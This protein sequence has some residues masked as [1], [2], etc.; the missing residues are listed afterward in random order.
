MLRSSL[1]TILVCVLPITGVAEIDG[2]AGCGRV[3]PNYNFVYNGPDPLK[4]QSPIVVRGTM[5]ERLTNFGIPLTQD[6]LILALRNP[7]PEVRYVAALRLADDDANGA[8]PDIVEA[9]GAERDPRARAYMA[10]ALTELGDPK[11]VQELH[12]AC[13]DATFPTDVKLDVAKFLLE[14]H[15][16]S[17]PKAVVAGF[18]AGAF[19]RDYAEDTMEFFYR[20]SPGQY[21]EVR[22]LL[23]NNKNG[24]VKEEALNVI[25]SLRDVDAIPDIESSLPKQTEFW[26]RGDMERVLKE[27]QELT[28]KPDTPPATSSH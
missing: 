15:E 18:E 8:I 20:M 27:L 10:C 2:W 21:A 26:V 25:N 28:A 14:L 23:L 4:D 17:C 22:A 24:G 3:P 11:G 9:L 12:R 5:F 16:S 7:K 19:V 13:D 6:G 1:F